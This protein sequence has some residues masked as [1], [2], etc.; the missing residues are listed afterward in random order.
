MVSNNK[1]EQWKKLTA[2]AFK[3]CFI[4]SW[5][6]SKTSEKQ[7]IRLSSPK[8]NIHAIDTSKKP[9]GL[10]SHT[11]TTLKEKLSF[12]SLKKTSEMEW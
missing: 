1:N 3:S 9:E 5:W 6:L 2:F 12:C 11:A 7:Q 4:I 10:V 8:K